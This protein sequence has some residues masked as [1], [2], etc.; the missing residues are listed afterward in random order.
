MRFLF[1]LLIIFFIT[2]GNVGAQSKKSKKKNKDMEVE[3]NQAP[4]SRDPDFSVGEAPSREAKRKTQSKNYKKRLDRK[5][6]E[7]EERMQANAKKRAKME[8]KMDKPQYSDPM[9]FGHKKKPKKRKLGKRKLCK[10]CGIV[11]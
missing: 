3:F 9:Y 5:V 1:P 11:H 6:E 2:V 4:S 10:E 8:K 7:Y